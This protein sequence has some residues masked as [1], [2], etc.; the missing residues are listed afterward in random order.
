[1]YQ[2]FM[3][4]FSVGYDD[5]IIDGTYV[6]VPYWLVYADFI[7]F[8]YTHKTCVSAHFYFALLMYADCR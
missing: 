2:L 8:I 7:L 3:T 5:D 6:S 1:M 4:D